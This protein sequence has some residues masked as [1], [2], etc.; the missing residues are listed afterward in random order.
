MKS[1]YIGIV[2]GMLLLLDVAVANGL[3]FYRPYDVYKTR[4]VRF[5]STNEVANTV[6]PGSN[7]NS[8]PQN[9]QTEEDYYRI[10]AYLNDVGRRR[11]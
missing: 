7:D 4:V 6:G 9:H 3:H 8:V 2:F 1:L 10:I 5:P 11:R